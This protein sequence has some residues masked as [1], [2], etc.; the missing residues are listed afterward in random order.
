MNWFNT[1]SIL[2]A[3]FLGVFW[4]AVFH[5]LRQVLGAQID[6]LPPL[7][8]YASLSTDFKTVCLLTLLGGLWFDSLSVNPLGTSVLPL[9]AV[10][11]AIY[12]KRELILKDQVFAQAVVGLVASA[13]VPVLTLVLLLTLGQAPLLGWGTLWQLAVM[14]VGGAVAT[15]VFFALFEWLQRTFVHRRVT[16]TSFRSDREIRRGR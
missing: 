9:F 4:Q 8:V 7:V 15:P 2:V 16:E 11:L 6:V 14:S 13:V 5:G 3:A 12:L 10:G 1:I